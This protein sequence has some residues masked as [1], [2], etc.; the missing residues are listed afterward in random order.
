MA[1]LVLLVTRQSMLFIH[2]TKKKATYGMQHLFS[3]VDATQAF[4]PNLILSFILC[5]YP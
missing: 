2:P 1:S 4:S 5:M 3:S